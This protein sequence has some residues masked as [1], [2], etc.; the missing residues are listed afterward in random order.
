MTIY[1]RTVTGAGTTTP[2][3]VNTYQCP[4]NLGF[5][6]K[7]T[8]TVSYTV[9]HTYDF[10]DD[11]NSAVTWY[12]NSVVGTKTVTADGS[13]LYPIRAIRVNNASGSGSI[14]LTVV[15]AGDS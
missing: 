1:T 2:V 14:A 13:Y 7:V 11:N 9:E 12:T 10:I 4:V 3:I 15:Q 5:G 6:C 8:G